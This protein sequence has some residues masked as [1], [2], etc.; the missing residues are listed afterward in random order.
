MDQSIGFLDKAQ[1]LAAIHKLPKTSW[2]EAC[3]P[4]AAK[5]TIPHGRWESACARLFDGSLR[6]A[7]FYMRFS[8][9]MNALPKRQRSGVLMLEGTLDG[10]AKAAK[11]AAGKSKPPHRFG[12]RPE[13]ARRKFGEAMLAPELMPGPEVELESLPKNPRDYRPQGQEIDEKASKGQSTA[14]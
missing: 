3:E 9:D 7:Q 2:Q 10:A 14:A 12:V 5:S 6:T 8:K 4:L 13:T 11:K 1:H